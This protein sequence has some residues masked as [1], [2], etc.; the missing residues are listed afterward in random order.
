MIQSKRN[1]FTL[2]E[3]LVVIA[4]I[5]ILAALLIPAVQAAIR[6][7]K[8][9]K[10]GMEIA[11][12]QSAIEAYKNDRFDYPPDFSDL[13]IV[14][15]HIARAFPRANGYDLT[16]LQAGLNPA[17]VDAA[18]ALVLWLSLTS[19]NPRAPFDATSSQEEFFSFDQSRLRDEDGDGFNEYYPAGQLAPY[20]YF[21]HRTYNTA[22]YAAIGE[23]TGTAKPYKEHK[24]PGDHSSGVQYVNPQT[25]QLISAG[26][27][28]DFG[29]DK[30]A[31]KVVDDGDGYEEGDYDNLA[32]FSEGRR[33]EDITHD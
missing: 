3:L 29:A 33:L 10:I 20:V 13:T 27:D 32:N 9:N 26:L 15:K 14:D 24:D 7:A 31:D 21:D 17:D 11:T 5:A 12:M 23:A 2:V 8:E 30:G 25:Y 6:A 18:E 1:A 19:N 28:D 22:S 4:I 16:K